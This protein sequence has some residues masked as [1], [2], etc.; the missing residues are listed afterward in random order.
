MY[1]AGFAILKRRAVFGPDV[2]QTPVPLRS[3]I[4]FPPGISTI[5]AVPG[6]AVTRYSVR[7]SSVSRAATSNLVLQLTGPVAMG[8]PGRWP[9]LRLSAAR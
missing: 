2:T 7:P 9:S 4:F 3:G 5:S 6:G 1:P 8:L